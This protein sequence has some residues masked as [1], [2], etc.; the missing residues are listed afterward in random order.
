V[1]LFYDSS[2]AWA[3]CGC[4]NLVADQAGLLSGRIPGFHLA[5]PGGDLCAM[6]DL[7]VP[8]GCARRREII[9]LGL[10]GPRHPG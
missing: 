4:I 3:A 5:H 1:L 7:D 6:D 2:I 9:R 10:A 8:I